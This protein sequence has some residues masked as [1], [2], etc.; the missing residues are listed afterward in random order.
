MLAWLELECLDTTSQSERRTTQQKATL[1]LLSVQTALLKQFV[2]ANKAF[3]GL[4][5]IQKQQRKKP[6][7]SLL[8]LV[9]QKILRKES[10]LPH[11]GLTRLNG[12]GS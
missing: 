1:L 12:N 8:R 4:E 2:L 9:M 5:R 11:T 7:E 10:A 3:Q 6:V